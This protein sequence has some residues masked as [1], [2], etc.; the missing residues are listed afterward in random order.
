M[1]KIASAAIAFFL[2]T[3]MCCAVSQAASVED[4]AGRTVTLK[5]PAQRIVALSPHIVENVFSA[6]AGEKLIGAVSY[7]NFPPEASDIPQVGSY[8]AFSLEHIVALKPDLV[9]MWGSGNGMATLQKFEALN[10][11]VYVSELRALDDVPESIRRIGALAGTTAVSEL[12]AQRIESAIADMRNRYGKSRNL[13]VFYQIWNEPLQTINGEHL[14]SQV[15]QLCGGKNV[16]TDAVSL[17]PQISLES[18]FL[19]NPDAIVAS[20]MGAARPEWLDVWRKY[21]SLSAVKSNALFFVD[22]NHIQRPTARIL[23][24]AQSLCSQLD[25][26]RK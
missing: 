8:N 7:S 24:G 17:A 4:F 5:K 11:P 10:I 9:I 15:I 18:I 23:L 25:Q 2:W 20:G 21:P 22:P 26:L 13:N 3:S 12:E 16:F 1:K 6:G 19:R 14:I